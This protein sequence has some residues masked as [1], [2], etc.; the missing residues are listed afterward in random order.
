MVQILKRAEAAVEPATNGV[1]RVSNLRGLADLV[2]VPSISTDGEHN[3]EVER[4]GSVGEVDI[5]DNG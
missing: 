1:V 5:L 3:H 4:T 2:S